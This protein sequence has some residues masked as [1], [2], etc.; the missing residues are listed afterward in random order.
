MPNFDAGIKGGSAAGGEAIER[1]KLHI[2]GCRF[3][4]NGPIVEKL[5]K[6]PLGESAETEYVDRQC[7]FF[8]IEA[9]CA[10]KLGEPFRFAEQ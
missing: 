4:P 7:G 10:R 3:G 8:Q 9:A 6:I 2:A 5:T 1:S